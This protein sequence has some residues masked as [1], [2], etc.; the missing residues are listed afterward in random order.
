MAAPAAPMPPPMVCKNGGARLQNTQLKLYTYCIHV[1][2]LM[3]RVLR[4]SRKL[5]RKKTFV[6]ICESFRCK[7]WG[8]GILWWHQR[9]IHENR[10]F[11]QFVKDFSLK[12]FSL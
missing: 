9:V 2:T 3:E 1:S 12:S 10:I 4:Y 7:I 5:S 8:H 11:H 6:V